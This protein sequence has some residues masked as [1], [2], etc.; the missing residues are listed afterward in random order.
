MTPRPIPFRAIADATYDWESWLGPEGRLLWVNP[1]VERITGYAVGEALAMPD[2]PLPAVH[3][4]DRARI[5]QVLQSALA[6][7]SGNDVEFRVLR[8]DGATRWA[9]ISWQSFGDESGASLGFRTSIR[10]I[11]ERKLSERRLQEALALAEQ[12]A[13]ARQAFLA[14]TSHE[15]RT[16]LQSILGWAQLLAKD[17]PDAEKRRKLDL[18]AQQSESLLAIVANVLELAALQLTS[19]EIVEEVFDLREELRNLL[20]AVRPLT[21]DTGLELGLEI[22]ARIPRRLRGDRMRL[23]QVLTNLLAN[24]LKFTER[25]RVDLRAARASRGRIRF[26]VEDTGVGLDAADLPRLFEPF[27]RAEDATRSGR[28]G[29][30]LGLSIAK[31][32]TDAMGGTLSV[33]SRRGVGSV[34]TVE[35]PLPTVARPATRAQARRAPV[36]GT[37]AARATAADQRSAHEPVAPDRAIDVLVVD[38]S[39]AG[40]ELLGEMLQGT[41]ARART[42]AT[43][44]EAVRSVLDSRPDLI[45]MDLQLPGLDGAT[46]AQLI[47]AQ[48]P[49]DAPRPRIVA[50]TANAFGRAL[51]LG[52]TGVMDGF[53]VKPVRLADL[54]ALLEH[55]REGR[56]GDGAPNAVAGFQAPAREDCLDPAIVQELAAARSKDGRPLLETTGR[57]ALEDSAE[58]LAELRRALR[59]K[60]LPVAAHLA[61]RIKGNCLVVGATGAAAEAQ[62][63]DEALARDDAPA[64]RAGLRALTRAIGQVE[65]ALRALGPGIERS[66]AARAT[67]GA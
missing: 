46:T 45:L 8:R 63:L 64:S 35:L 56:D 51:A 49:P 41:G 2:Y 58:C 6:G 18:V 32:L 1:A 5:E 21:T 43:G 34:F 57:R 37:R 20:D 29:T 7:L 40:R 47:R 39:P 44:E 28:G 65:Q 16:P 11:H 12:S 19:P 23:R 31:A 60:S 4:E 38:D 36:A 42:A 26:A 66:V 27:V 33:A 61:H 52:P 67:D 13:V 10:D 48:T 14:N 17:E 9:A 62:R 15:L 54:R 50:V 3:P 30:G 24:A 55:V 53:L 25:G 59:R 22:D